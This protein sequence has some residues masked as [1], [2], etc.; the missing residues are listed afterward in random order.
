MGERMKYLSPISANLHNDAKRNEEEYR[1]KLRKMKIIAEDADIDDLV[2]SHTI[3]Q[4]SLEAKDLLT[5][6]TEYKTASK[7]IKS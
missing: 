1:S 3:R 5:D 4:T 7:E 6:I 2:K